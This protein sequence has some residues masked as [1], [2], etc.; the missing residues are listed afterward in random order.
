MKSLQIGPTGIYDFILTITFLEV[1]ILAA[2]RTKTL[3]IWPA[4]EKLIASQQQILTD[5][6]P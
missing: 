3:T 5:N 4:I 1:A 6:F 2:M